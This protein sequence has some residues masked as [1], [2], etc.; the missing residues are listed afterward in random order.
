MSHDR[1]RNK[2]VNK[3]RSVRELGIVILPLLLSKLIVR[4]QKRLFLQIIM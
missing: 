1:V 2:M 3:Q 4:G